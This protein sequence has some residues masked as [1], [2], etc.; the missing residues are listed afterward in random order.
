MRNL[1]L[2]LILANVLF[3]L[4]GTFQSDK[5]LPPGVARLQESDLGPPLGVPKV[6][7]D[8]DE[9]EEPDPVPEEKVAAD[10][11]AETES[12]EEGAENGEEDHAHKDHDET[13]SACACIT[14]LE[15][16]EE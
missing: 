16:H 14:G 7:N 4:W 10:D 9:Q 15:T 13:G 3:F 2:A 1:L 6:E 11:S 12:A 5:D 8:V